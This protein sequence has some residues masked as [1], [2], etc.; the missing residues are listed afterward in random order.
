MSVVIKSGRPKDTLRIANGT[1]TLRV[2]RENTRLERMALA[3]EMYLKDRNM[4]NY[5]EIW[6]DFQLNQASGQYNISLKDESDRIL[7][8]I[9]EYEENSSGIQVF[10]HETN[11]SNYIGGQVSLAM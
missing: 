11:L 2:I 4:L 10:L 7:Y 1:V 8:K 9:F 6:G 3:I 5:G